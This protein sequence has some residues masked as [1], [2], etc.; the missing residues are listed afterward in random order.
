MVPTFARKLTRLVLFKKKFKATKYSELF[1]YE[2]TLKTVL[3]TFLSQKVY[4]TKVFI[5][6][7]YAIIMLIRRKKKKK[8]H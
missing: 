2:I 6:E 3:V 4:F 1:P 7:N 8:N 5:S